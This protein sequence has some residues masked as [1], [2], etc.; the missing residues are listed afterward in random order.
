MPSG[1]IVIRC[2]NH[3]SARKTGTRHKRTRQA[4]EFGVPF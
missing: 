2:E 1:L 4:Q 3:G